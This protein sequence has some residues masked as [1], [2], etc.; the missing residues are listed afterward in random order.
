M[1]VH[2]SFPE[3]Y[4]PRNLPMLCP[5]HNVPSLWSIRV[6]LEKYCD[7]I[8]VYFQMVAACCTEPL[9]NQDLVFPSVNCLKKIVY[10][11]IGAYLRKDSTAASLE[12]VV[13][14]PFL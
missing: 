9:I 6:I 11:V 10:E 2:F 3:K 1:P 4:T 5:Q 12:T 14:G 7:A 13:F 8:T